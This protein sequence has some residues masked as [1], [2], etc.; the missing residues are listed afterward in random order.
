MAGV[1]DQTNQ[2]RYHFVHTRFQLPLTQN[3]PT[4]RTKDLFF[5]DHHFRRVKSMQKQVVSKKWSSVFAMILTFK[6]GAL[7]K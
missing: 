6:N 1:E 7:Q 3:Q 5:S 4:G 2:K